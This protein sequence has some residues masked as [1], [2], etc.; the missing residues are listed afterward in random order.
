MN[1][2]PLS[3]HAAD[4]AP[5]LAVLLDFAALLSQEMDGLV[6]LLNLS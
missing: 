4:P 5:E 2:K 1:Q 6:F 3:N